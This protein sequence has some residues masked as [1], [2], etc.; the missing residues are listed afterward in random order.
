MGF[1][2]QVRYPSVS[3]SS[4]LQGGKSSQ[5]EN[6]ATWGAGILAEKTRDQIGIVTF[7]MTYVRPIAQRKTLAI[8]FH[9]LRTKPFVL[10]R[11]L[12]ICYPSLL[13]TP[14]LKERNTLHLA[15]SCCV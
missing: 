15:V 1:A 12:K 13:L 7:P 8:H 4:S 11:F 3:S 6:S 14:H 9:T 5:S 2:K 10:D